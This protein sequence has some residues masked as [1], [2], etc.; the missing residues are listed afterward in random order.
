MLW[1]ET[2]TSTKFAKEFFWLPFIPH[3]VAYFGPSKTC[4]SSFVPI[5]IILNLINYIENINN[6]YLTPNRYTM[7]YFLINLI[8]LICIIN[9]DIFV[10]SW[11][12]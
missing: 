2:E 12:I 10:L 11:Q 3:M 6:I 7:K 1:I 9:I 4:H 5:Q 8:I